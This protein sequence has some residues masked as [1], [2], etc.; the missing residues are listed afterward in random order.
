MTS[1]ASAPLTRAIR[2]AAREEIGALQ[3]PVSIPELADKIK[4]HHPSIAEAIVDESVDYVR[5]TITTSPES[6]F[7]RYDPPEGSDMSVGAKARRIYWGVRGDRYCPEWKATERGSRGEGA[8]RG[9][10]RGRG[11][12]KSKRRSVSRAPS[13][14]LAHVEEQCRGAASEEMELPAG[15]LEKLPGCAA[16]EGPEST[17]QWEERAGREGAAECA[18]ITEN[19][20]YGECAWENEWERECRAESPQPTSAS[21]P[22]PWAAEAVE[23]PFLYSSPLRWGSVFGSDCEPGPEW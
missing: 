4:E 1:A 3:R 6:E 12:G 11:E 7:V 9:R 14:S 21:G 5:V 20:E 13:A 2:R 17:W 22:S 8:G 10:G 15:T 16:E 18:W 19:A 23:N